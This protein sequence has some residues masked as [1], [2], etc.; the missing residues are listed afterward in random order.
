MSKPHRITVTITRDNI[1]DCPFN[2]DGYRCNITGVYCPGD[3]FKASPSCPLLT[4][5]SIL[6]VNDKGSA[7]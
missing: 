7:S 1:E 3:T 2:D 5:G 6:V 4:H